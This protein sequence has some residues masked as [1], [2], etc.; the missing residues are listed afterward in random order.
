[1]NF[2]IHT[3]GQEKQKVIVIDSALDNANNLIELAASQPFAPVQTNSYPGIRRNLSSRIADE[4]GYVEALRGL[5]APIVQEVY[6]VNF[7]KITQAAFSLIT[8]RPEQ[9]HPLVRLPHF[10]FPTPLRFALLHFLSPIPQGGTG[11]YRH[12]ATGIEKIDPENKAIYE[13]SIITD[14]ETNGIPDPKYISG[15]TQ[16]FEQIG[17][18]EGLFNRVLI[19]PANILH[20][21]H[22][23]DDFAF[24]P[25]P[26]QG[27]L[28]TNLFLQ[29]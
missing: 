21:A 7:F 25:D 2:E 15:T 17:F 1:M 28:T 16:K 27:R 19:Y 18:F 3:I 12:K 8:I 29:G 23:P 22:I 9:T 24:S 10:D 6:N 26:N 20:S 4:S 14:L 13:K 11:F 5:A